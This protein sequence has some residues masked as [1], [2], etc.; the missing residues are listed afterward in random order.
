MKDMIIGRHKVLGLI[1]PIYLI[2]LLVV[3]FFGFGFRSYTKYMQKN[4]EVRESEVMLSNKDRPYVTIC[5]LNT[6][7][8]SPG[9][10]KSKWGENDLHYNCPNITNKEELYSCIDRET[11]TISDILESSEITNR[12]T[13]QSRGSFNWTYKI[14]RLSYGKCFTTKIYPLLCKLFVY[15]S[16][17]LVVRLPV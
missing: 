14:S 2:T 10:K 13:K 1:K 4:I 8:T 6:N 9:W 17:H 3:F 11:F 7:S 12:K 16:C 5:A 15:K